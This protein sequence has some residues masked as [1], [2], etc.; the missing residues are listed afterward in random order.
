MNTF[1]KGDRVEFRQ[2]KDGPLEY[3]VV[4]KGGKRITVVLDGGTHQ[5][6]GPP[7]AF[8]PS[9]H[10]LPKDDPGPMD[11]YGVI[12]FKSAGGEETERFECKIT[13]DGKPIIIASNDGNGG[14][15]RYRPFKWESAKDRELVVAFDKAATDWV[16][17]LGGDGTEKPYECGDFWLSWY[18][19][20]RPFG[21]TF[22][23]ALKKFRDEMAKYRQPAAK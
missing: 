13:L 10:P 9:T 21:I 1:K 14:S 11:R 7:A 22:A 17:Q 15:N 23:A 12:G 16:L 19:H 8:Q 2:K 5:V 18:V 3:G 4:S 6:S 20:E